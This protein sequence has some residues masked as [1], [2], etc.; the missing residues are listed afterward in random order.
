MT[1]KSNL[2]RI[3]Q[4]LLLAAVIFFGITITN[5]LDRNRREMIL[6][7]KQLANLN[8]GKTAVPAA[9]VNPA[10]AQLS[11]LAGYYKTDSPTDGTLR[12][13]IA[14]DTGSLNPVT[15]NE[16]TAQ[17][18]IGL[19]TAP[20]GTRDLEHPEKFVP[21]I[22]ESWQVS[23]DGKR[24]TLKLRKGVMW[25]SYNDPDSGESVPEREVTAHDFVFYLDVIRNTKVNAGALRNYFQDLASIRAEGD[26]QLA[27]E[28]KNEYFRS[29]EMSLGLI[30]LPRHFYCAPDGKFDPV[31]F[32]DDYKRNNMIVGC[33]P[34]KLVKHVKDQRFELERFENYFG[35]ALGISPK[36]KKRVFEI[37]KA[38]N[39]R[40]Q[41]LQS[42]ELDM[43]SLSAEQWVKRTNSRE[44]SRK[45][46]VSGENADDFPL[47]KHEKFRRVKH[48]ANA[49]FY[50]GY[51]QKHEIFADKRVRQALTM[52]CNRE[53]ILKEVYHNLG[54]VISG[55]FFCDS[56]YYDPAIK[57][58]PF[59][60]AA[61]EK[62][63][64][65]A[66]WRDSDGDGILDK[67]GKKFV[68]TALQVSGNPV[69][70]R[71]L[72]IFKEDLAKA[73]IDMKIAILEWPVY[74]NKLDKRDYE[75]CSLGWQLPF[76]SDPYQVWHSSQ[77]AGTGSNHI[78]FVNKDADRLIEAIRREL[79]EKKRISLCREFHRL[80]HEEQPYTFLVVPES[81]QVLSGRISNVRCFPLGLSSECF[82]IKTQE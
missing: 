13:A 62:L 40:F 8:T 59:D 3:L 14:S 78:G 32:N 71:I 82:A 2:D 77:T 23:P 44:F 56:P 67:N 26:H 45:V 36:I 38:D 73:H 47:Q 33:G 29:L 27:L 50:I 15:G 54:K 64:K 35:K 63:L 16:A 48:L 17:H 42:G 58:L 10:P 55:P 39:T 61:A 5:A 74:I 46:L 80:I 30:P 69:Q 75:V 41:M 53:R 22:A 79:D 70:E 1:R 11:E 28:W 76:E 21:M 4:I 6:L 18:L 34:Y 65:E 9:S 24:I 12:T 7:Q 19:C 43:L 72:S 57:P 52:L 60:P 66:G 31:K 37:V 20:L 25:Q 49:Y 68:F 81:L 51:N